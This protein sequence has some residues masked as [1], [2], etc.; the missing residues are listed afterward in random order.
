MVVRERPTLVINI[1]SLIKEFIYANYLIE[2]SILLA[3]QSPSCP[4]TV[5]RVWPSFMYV[6]FRISVNQMLGDLNERQPYF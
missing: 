1:H 3:V 6:R 5:R 2:L 4:G